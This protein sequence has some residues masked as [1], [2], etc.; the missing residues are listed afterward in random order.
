[1]SVTQETT[2]RKLRI[3]AL[4]LLAGLAVEAVSLAGLHSPTGFLSFAMIGGT[5]IAA[6]IAF[7][8]WSLVT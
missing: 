6:A 1:M 8:L 2:G 4:L 5:L 3:S 7:Y